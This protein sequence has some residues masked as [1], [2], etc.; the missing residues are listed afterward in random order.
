VRIADFGRSIFP[1]NPPHTSFLHDNPTGTWPSVDSLYLAP[2]CYENPYFRESDV[3]SFGLILYQLLTGQTPFPKH[4][5]QHQIAYRLIM[6]ENCPT[7]PQCVLPASRKLITDGWD[8]EPGYR[9]SFD[10]IVERLMEMKFKLIP[11]VN[12]MIYLGLQRDMSSNVRPKSIRIP[13][14][15]SHV[16]F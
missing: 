10:E 2:E 11:G 14:P 3:F 9:L 12:Q 1:D 15:D 8:K 16:G 7:I 13:Y 5:K 4:V 6:T